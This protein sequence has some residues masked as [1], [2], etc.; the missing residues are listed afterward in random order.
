MNG[1]TFRYLPQATITAMLFALGHFLSFESAA[2]AQERP[3]PAKDATDFPA[4]FNSQNDAELTADDAEGLVKRMT[5]PDGFRVTLFASEPQVQQPVAITTDG[6]GRLWVAEMYTYAESKV[7]FETRLRDRIVILEDSDG[8]GRC[9]KRTVF[10]DGGQRLTAVA[11]GFG[12]VYALCAPELLFIPDR[13]GDDRPDGPPVVVLDGWNDSAVRHNIVNGLT[14]G[15]DGWLYGRHGILATSVVGK[16]GT[17]ESRRARINCGIWRYHPIRE[18]FE[19]VCQGTTNPWGFDF[20]EHGQMFFINTVI[21]H[22]WHIIPGAY[23]RR[24]YGEHLDPHVYSLIDQHADHFH[25]DTVEAWSDIRKGVTESTSKAGG[26]HAHVGMMI[27]LGDNW[28]DAYRGNVFTLNLHGLRV[29]RDRLERHGSGYVGKH[30]PDFLMANNRWFRGID[31]LYGPDGGVYVA[32]WADV[33]ECHENDGVHRTSGRIY[34]VSYDSKAARAPAASR[35]NVDRLA[36]QELVALQF[37]RNDWFVRQARRVLQERTAA[38]RLDAAAVARSL[39]E[40]FAARPASRDKLRALWGLYAIGQLS[41]ERLRGL[42]EH[43]DDHVRTWAIRLLADDGQ[44]TAADMPLLVKRAQ[45]DAS[46]QVRLFLASSLQ[47]LPA[48]ERLDLASAL[49]EHAEDADDHNQP[50]MLWYGIEPLVSSSPA[51]AVSL[52]RRSRIPLLP[53]Y[54]ARRLAEEIDQSGAAID[55]L[56]TAATQADE[57]LARAV[58]K[59]MSEGLRG[60]RRAPQPK[61]WAAFHARWEPKADESLRATL[62]ELSALFGDGRALDELRKLALDGGADGEARRAAL[63]AIIESRPD[64]L[65]PLLKKSISDRALA[66]VAARGL[67]SFADADT[68]RLLLDRWNTLTP[69]DRRAALET[70]VARPAY[71]QSLLDAVAAGRLKSQEISAWHA[72]QIRSFNDPALLKRLNEIWGEVRETSE[73][74]QRLASQLRPQLAPELLA[75]ADLAQGRLVFEKSCGNCHALFGKGG[76][77]GPDLTGANRNNLEYLLENILDPSASVAADFR[78]SVVELKDGR[79]LTGVVG[80]PTART[81]TIQTATEKLTVPRDEIERTNPSKASLMP[82]GLLNM[83]TPEQIRDLFA[84]VMSRR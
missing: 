40:A 57:E 31:L 66:G 75:K 67:A 27:Y 46:A 20:D 3:S 7:N 17:P 19:V 8:D 81:V 41:D 44:L 5:T 25:W 13:D 69:D 38:G 18:T 26:G 84:F 42:L 78:T 22:L 2:P 29:N 76:A 56:L 74:R 37:H 14:L 52:A 58:V 11:V 59:G 47:R 39:D 64:D 1:R 54:I 72:R 30:E 83:L 43:P 45:V 50:L 79:V 4:P 36:D 12:G 33:G 28:P 51:A 16:P 32:D 55:S 68:P 21:G 60:W 34:K 80:A 62:R 82:E 35:V 63:R 6:R 48:A 65:L 71:A 23:Y 73:E 10:W 53:Q 70:L 61:S 15:P 9:D 49:V 24:M 77:I